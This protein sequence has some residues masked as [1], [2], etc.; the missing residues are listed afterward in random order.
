MTEQTAAEKYA[1]LNA[2]ADGVRQAQAHVRQAALA[3]YAE[4]GADRWR[5]TYGTVIVKGA[6]ASPTPTVGDETAF[7]AWVTEHHPSEVETV[8]RV[9]PAFR[10][11]IAKRLAVQPP[12]DE[13]G[14]PVVID[15]HTGEVVPWA[16]VVPPPPPSVA[17][18]GGK[19]PKA[20]EAK[21]NAG[22]LLLDRIAAG[23]LALA[24]AGGDRS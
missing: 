21:A 5:T 1:A 11:V 7:L 13:D 9:R 24:P 6:D 8:V 10:E 22:R 4:H 16:R 23:R 3:D 12:T 19:D 15:Q 14:D 2:I 18:A 20:V 17:M